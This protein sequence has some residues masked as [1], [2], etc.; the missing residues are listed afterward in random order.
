M[1]PDASPAATERETRA[2]DAA[3]LLPLLGLFLLM[4]PII[5]L[6]V[7]PVTIA[8]VP[9]IVAYVFGV[10]LA[11]VAAAAWLARTLP[12]DAPADEECSAPD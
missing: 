2:R 11:L 5:A 12:A 7:Q 8:G 1:P 10:W 3:V 4:P 9:L 6:F